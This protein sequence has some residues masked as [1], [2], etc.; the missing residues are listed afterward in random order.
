MKIKGLDLQPRYVRIAPVAR[1]LATRTSKL[2]YLEFGR[3]CVAIGRVA[4]LHK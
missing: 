4:Y 1:S 2:K 3:A